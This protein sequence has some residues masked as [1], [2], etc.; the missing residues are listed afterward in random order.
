[1][2]ARPW[3]PATALLLV[4]ACSDAGSPVNPDT[5]PAPARVARVAVPANY[6]V[7]DT[8][9]RDGIAFVCAWNTGVIIYDVGNG[10]KGGSP[11]APVEISRLLTA[12]N[13][14]PGGSAVHNAWWFHNPVTGEKRYLFIGQE[15]A[16]TIPTA[17][18][19]DIHVVDVSDLSQPREVA[20]YHMSVSPPAGTHNFWMDEPGQILYAAYYNQGVVA[21]DVSGTLS[22]DLA[23]REIARFKPASPTFV[24]GV[25]LV[26][27]SLYA[28]DM[29][30]GLSQLRLSGGA[31]SLLSGGG[32]VLER[33]SADLWVGPSHAYTG[34][35][36]GQPRGLV[37]GN[38]LK[39]WSLSA[40]GAPTLIDSII[41]DSVSTLSDVK[42]TPDGKL[43]IVSA[44]GGPRGGL[45]VYSLAN[46]AKPA[47]V[48]WTRVTSGLHTAK[49]AA[50]GGRT[51][52]FAAEN[53]GPLV[54]PALD[55]YEVTPF[56]P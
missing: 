1:M 41:V 47:L 54:T 32:N 8:F 15:G 37:F 53:P 24:W 31:F 40:T 38:A 13:G 55:I 42:G 36:G 44:E 11:Q 49:V 4:A 6:G 17:T 12:A 29:L 39:I 35:W 27:T 18:T 25:H 19:G 26:G 20:F 28:T 21:L 46:P 23:S 14:V 56:S 22:G 16:A 45:Y 51:Y 43:L 30:N 7:H 3:A 9:I 48:A 10:M 5:L 50:I 34:T 33:Y 2:T 52:V